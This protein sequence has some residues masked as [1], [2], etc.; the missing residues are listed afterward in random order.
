MIGKTCQRGSSFSTWIRFGGKG[1]TLLVEG[2]KFAVLMRV[3]N[4]LERI[5]WRV[6]EIIRWCCAV[7]EHC[8]ATLLE[9][10]RFSLAFPEGKCF[11]GI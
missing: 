10:K 8:I 1:L 4:P 5:G 2:V 6:V 3:G 11:V 9:E 7:I